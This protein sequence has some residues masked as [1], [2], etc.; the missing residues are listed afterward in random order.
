MITE[1]A[2]KVMQNELERYK[3]T[4]RGGRKKGSIPWNKGQKGKYKLCHT[5]ITRQKV[6]CHY[7]I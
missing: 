4:H 7:L 1:L 6:L 2:Q 3:K 5:K